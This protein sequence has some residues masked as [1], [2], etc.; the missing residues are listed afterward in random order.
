MTRRTKA[1]TESQKA[2]A[3]RLV[4]ND[5]AVLVDET[6]VGPESVCDPQNVDSQTQKRFDA[7][8]LF[9]RLQELI[10]VSDTTDLRSDMDTYVQKLRAIFEDEE[11]AY[12]CV[13]QAKLECTDSIKASYTSVVIAPPKKKSG[14]LGKP[15]TLLIEATKA[16]TVFQS[17]EG[18]IYTSESSREN[19][20]SSDLRKELRKYYTCVCVCII[21]INRLGF[22]ILYVSPTYP[23]P[24]IFLIFSLRPYLPVNS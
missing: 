17:L 19:A 6:D 24:S 11:N 8:H 9:T 14:E 12:M 4:V 2:N 5:D 22:F 23:P 13:L 15:Q 18:L 1:K 10:M 21:H 3:E 20:K 16:E 7:R